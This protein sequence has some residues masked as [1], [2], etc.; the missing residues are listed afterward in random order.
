VD[1][2]AVSTDSARISGVISGTV[3]NDL[4]KTGSGTLE[5][6]GANTYLGNTMIEEGVLSISAAGNLGA[7]SGSNALV[8]NGGT[9]RVTAA[10][11]L[12]PAE[13]AVSV[14]APGA[15]LEVVAGADLTINGDMSGGGATLNKAGWGTLILNG[16]Q[17]YGR[18]SVGAG[19]AWVSGLIGDGG[20]TVEVGGGAN[21]KMGGISQTLSGLSIGAGA[22]VT[23]A[24]GLGSLNVGVGESKSLGINAIPEPSASLFL[25]LGA[26]FGGFRSRRGVRVTD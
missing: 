18:L 2:V 10:G 22:T 26:I 8:I 13:R 16:V 9:L 14:G 1:N 19:T 6:T 7:T 12:L 15:T 24:S 23:F 4:L 11:V 17:G 3:Q 5:L 21:L 20:S 25:A